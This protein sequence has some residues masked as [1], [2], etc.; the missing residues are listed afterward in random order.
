MSDRSDR[1]DREIDHL[2]KGSA[3][4]KFL[5]D[6]E[7]HAAIWECARL[8][9]EMEDARAEI[10]EADHVTRTTGEKLAIVK[11]DR[12]ELRRQLAEMQGKNATDV[13]CSIDGP[14]SAHQLTGFLDGRKLGLGCRGILSR[15]A[16]A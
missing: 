5:D 9:V 16:T 3:L 4:R 1:I 14:H 13:W 15:V 12:D 6:A 10:R 2:L 11:Q 7:F 8:I